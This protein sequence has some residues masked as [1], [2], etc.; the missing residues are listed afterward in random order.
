MNEVPGSSPL[1]I[2]INAERSMSLI[3]PHCS[4]GQSFRP[5][6]RQRSDCAEA[7]SLLQIVDTED[8]SAVS[9]DGPPSEIENLNAR[10]DEQHGDCLIRST[11]SLPMN[12]PHVDRPDVS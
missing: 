9:T 3:Q 4:A 8:F 7:D 6:I 5:P 12:A 10:R 11:A 2:C 1:T